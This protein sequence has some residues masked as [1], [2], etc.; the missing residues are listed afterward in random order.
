[1]ADLKKTF[2]LAFAIGGKLDPSFKAA[3]SQAAADI[4]KLSKKSAEAMKFNKLN[5]EFNAAMQNFTKAAGNM[6]AAW[7][8]VG[9]SIMNPLKQIIALG[10]VAGAA[11]YGLATKTAQMGDAAAKNSQKLGMTTKEYGQLTYAAEQ[12]GLKVDEFVSTMKKFNAENIKAVSSGKN[13]VL[14]YGKKII[15]LKDSTGALK[16]N[17]QILL[18][19]VDAMAKMKNHADKSKLAMVMFGKAGVDMLPFLEQGRGA[20]EAL[21]IEADKLGV[22]FSE[23]AAGNSVAFMDSL[24]RLKSA[25]KGLFIEIG[26]Q[27][28]PVLTKLNDKIK[29][30]IVANRELIGQKVKEFVQDVV[31]WIKDNR[32]GIIGLKNSV[33]EFIRQVGVWIEKNGGLVEVLKKVGKAFLALKALG[34]V[35]SLLGAATA[36]ATFILSIMKLVTA[37][38][39]LLAAFGGFKVIAGVISGLALPVLAVVA[40]VAALGTATYLLIKNWEGVVYF[41]K[42]LTT[43]VPIFFNDLVEDIKGVFGRLPGWLQNILA[44]IKNIILGPIQAVQDLLAGN[45]KGFIINMG[46]FIIS[47]L[48]LIPSLIATTGN[49]IIKALF[50]VDILGAIKDWITPSLN[51]LS[52]ML[53][54][55]IDTIKNFFVGEFSRIKD[56]FGGGF[57]NGIFEVLRSIPTLF[58]RM[59]NDVVKALFGVDLI[60]VGKEWLSGF[61]AGVSGIYSAVQ[62]VF[63]A[64]VALVKGIT[65]DIVSIFSTMIGTVKDFFVGEFVRIKEA[66]KGGFFNGIKEVVLSVPTLFIRMIADVAKALIRLDIVSIG[67]GWL[68]GFGDVIGGID[69]V[70]MR[71]VTLVPR[72]MND[73]VKAITG[74]DVIGTVKSW[75][76]P[77]IDTVT[78]VFDTVKG[79]FTG[80]VDFV[81][82]FFMGDLMGIK[83]AFSGGFLNGIREIFTRLTTLIPRLL[84]D[85]VKAIAGI[86]ILK[87]GK[88]WIQKF[89]DGVLSVLK[90]AAGAVKNAVKGLLPES[91]INVAGGVVKT[92]GGAAKAVG[93]VMPKFSDGGIATSPSIVAEDGRPEMV[94]PLTKPK[95]AAEL[96]KQIND[97]APVMPPKEASKPVQAVKEVAS[98]IGESKPVQAFKAKFLDFNEDSASMRRTRDRSELIAKQQSKP[99]LLDE[100]RGSKNVTNTTNNTNNT[101]NLGGGP[102]S[103]SPTINVSGGGD[104]AAIKAAVNEALANARK[105]FEQWYNQREHSNRRVAMA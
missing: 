38:K 87:T 76:S 83:E 47:K 7:S 94:I 103:F 42:N 70:L 55:T 89:I 27:F 84:N 41:F 20:I 23:E 40:A 72:L 100:L 6:G 19:T 53:G 25:F 1:M 90:N 99:S 77:I 37:T 102:V 49:E 66:F 32:E 54:T 75:L 48:T 14:A 50:G 8:N 36:T 26:S 80:A 46:K 92:I 57:F 79:V 34:I 5:K 68:R 2:E 97:A 9:A 64:V 104:P 28:H 78:G 95:R 105:D 18:E 69:N 24:T 51:V 22:T 62:N 21:G 74:V 11:V 10:A 56:A 17:R 4:A 31:K 59:G 81:K 33:V 82:G 30:W 85:A 60:G 29:D 43:T 58:I 71:I 61:V 67:K 63:G 16:S 13:F 52:D 88:D 101:N 93:S 73:A 44:P 65:K 96:I 98:R 3:N 91:V 86:D 12:S 45:I 39:A 15:S 35:F